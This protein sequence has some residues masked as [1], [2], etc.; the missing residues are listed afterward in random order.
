MTRKITTEKKRW[1]FGTKN[2]VH[3]C[4]DSSGGGGG[5]G[6]GRQSRP[7]ATVDEPKQTKQKYN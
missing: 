3:F 2:R 1:H 4:N 7:P 6:N 5:G